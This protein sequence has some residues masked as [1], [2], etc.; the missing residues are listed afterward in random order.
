MKTKIYKPIFLIGTGRSG[1]TLAYDL[2]SHH[3]DLAWFSNLTSFFPRH[4]RLAKLSVWLNSPLSVLM[5]AKIKSLLGPSEAWSIWRM[6]YGGF[7]QPFRP[8]AREDVTNRARS[9][10]RKAVEAHLRY[11]NKPRFLTKYTGWSR[12]GFID[13][14]FPDALF[15]HV[16]RDGRAVANSLMNVDFWHGWGG[17][18]GW[19]GGALPEKFEKEWMSANRSFVVLVAIQ[20][21]ILIRELQK[22]REIV[23]DGRFLEIKYED[24]VREPAATLKQVTEFCELG[25]RREFEKYL[26]TRRLKNANY[27]WETDLTEEQK[28][29]LNACLHDELKR[30]NYI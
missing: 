12:V 5:P 7:P 26:T 6:C 20:W 2:L 16:L 11:Q 13:A 18:E 9:R 25:E 22:S 30:L 8:L 29:L 27:K 15:I 17:P 10:I 23:G 21:K 14:V 4:P 19:R 1:T 28:E 24:I 3:P